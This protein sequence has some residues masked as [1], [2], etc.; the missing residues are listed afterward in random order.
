[1]NSLKPNTVTVDMLDFNLF[2]CPQGQAIR[3]RAMKTTAASIILNLF[4]LGKVDS[5]KY[6]ETK[7]SYLINLKSLYDFRF[8]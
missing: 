5:L 6:L 7:F 1:M 8:K 2:W 4:A 3:L